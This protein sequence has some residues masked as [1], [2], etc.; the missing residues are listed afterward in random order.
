MKV[1]RKKSLDF[2]RYEKE[3]G[4]RRFI[5][6]SGFK[7]TRKATTKIFTFSKKTKKKIK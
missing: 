7:K 5:F 4:K 2:V 3:E 6:V 1:C